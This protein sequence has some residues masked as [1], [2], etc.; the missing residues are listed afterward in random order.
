MLRK[1][2]FLIWGVWIWITLACLRIGGS[3]ADRVPAQNKDA[4]FTIIA[5]VSVN[6]HESDGG[7]FT[8]KVDYYAKAYKG[9]LV[10]IDCLLFPPLEDMYSVGFIHPRRSDE[11]LLQSGSLIFSAT[12]PGDYYIECIGTENL[13]AGVD[14]F[15]ILEA[16]STP[17]PT[18][19]A[20]K[21]P[22]ITP[23]P[24]STSIVTLTSTNTSTLPIQPSTG[25]ILFDKNGIQSSRAV[26]GKLDEV[27]KWCIPEVTIAPDGKISGLCEY[28]GQT[29]VEKAHVTATVSGM[30]DQSGNITF[31]Y[32]VSEIGDPNGA[33]R[34]SF[35]GKG[36]FTSNK[37]AAGTA[38]FTYSCN[39]GAENLLWCF[40]FTS[41]S[42]DGTIPWR[43]EPTMN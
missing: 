36:A 23:T 16:T 35:E 14:Y 31:S 5:A 11:H 12:E 22:T 25:K 37:Q 27:I 38:V 42:A 7:S 2:I 20:T 3:P 8:V 28:T 24:T 41:E 29:F 10:P 4:G 33:W 6:P 34:I 1:R 30:V 21:T 17:T 15:K 26:G 13:D 43:F 32:D 9:D 39:S 18:P 40:G 19:T